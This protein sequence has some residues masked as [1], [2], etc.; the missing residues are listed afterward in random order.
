MNI[1]ADDIFGLIVCG[2]VLLFL[3]VGFTHSYFYM[4]KEWNNGRCRKCHSQWESFDMDSSGATGYKC[5]CGR[6]IWK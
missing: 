1:S 3:I 4:K 6:Y 2:G 5:L